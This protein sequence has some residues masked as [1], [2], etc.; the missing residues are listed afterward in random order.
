MENVNQAILSFSVWLDR[1]S[2]RNN[3]QFQ[4]APAMLRL[5]IERKSHPRVTAAACGTLN[6]LQN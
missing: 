3:D 2:T 4:S 6:A 1:H 5:G